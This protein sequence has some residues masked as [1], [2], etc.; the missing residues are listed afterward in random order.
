MNRQEILV[1][2][3]LVNLKRI[4]LKQEEVKDAARVLVWMRYKK[5]HGNITCRI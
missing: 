1:A 2:Y 4:I 3:I 5:T